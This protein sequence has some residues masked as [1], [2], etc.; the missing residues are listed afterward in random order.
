ME[1][2]RPGRTFRYLDGTVSRLWLKTSGLAATT[3]SSAHPC[4]GSPRQDL[5]GGLRV[6]GADGT[7]DL[8]EVLRPAIGRSSRSTEVMTT[9]SRPSFS[10]AIATLSGSLESSAVEGRAHIAEGTGAV[11]ISP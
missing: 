9:C 8:G 2:P 5:D 6:A 10:T 4:A 3:I 11:Q 1:I 7:N